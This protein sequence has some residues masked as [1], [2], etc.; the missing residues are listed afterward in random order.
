MRVRDIL[1]VHELPLWLA[2]ITILAFLGFDLT[3][4]WLSDLEYPLLFTAL[5]LWLFIMVIWNSFE[6]AHHVEMLAESI[7]EPLGTLILTLSVTSI[8]IVTIVNIMLVGEESPTLVRDTMYAIIMI[9]LNGIIGLSLLLGGLRYREQRY[10][11]RGSIEFASVILVLAVIGLILPDFTM[12]TPGPTFSTGQTIFLIFTSLGVYAIFLYMQTLSHTKHFVSPF[13]SQQPSKPLKIHIRYPQ[14]SG[15]YHGIMLIA[16]LIPTLVIAE[17]IAVPIDAT[18]TDLNPPQALGGL[19]VAVLVLAPE[20]VSAIRASLANR[21]Q[22]SVNI[23]LGSVLATTALTIPIVLTIGLYTG[24]S[25]ILG[26][27]KPNIALLALTLVTVIVTFA[28]GRT[29][30]LQGSLHLLLFFAY[31]MLIF[32]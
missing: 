16:Y 12:T 6:V 20:A 10:N 7:P 2:W 19:L 4:R 17:Q 27:S 13:E 3:D 29:S 30:I 15:L 26:L 8:E 14:Q 1:L 5:F 31:I 32:D 28:S 23:A 21:L 25:I 18:V 9:V 11:L 22:R 24:Q